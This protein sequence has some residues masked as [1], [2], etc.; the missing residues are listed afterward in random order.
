[1]LITKESYESSPQIEVLALLIPKLKGESLDFKDLKELVELLDLSNEEK[2]Y[3]FQ[4]A[5]SKLKKESLTFEDLEELIRL[6]ELSQDNDLKISIIE[7]GIRKLKED[8]LNSGRIETLVSLVESADQEVLSDDKEFSRAEYV[9]VT[10]VRRSKE[11]SL[12]LKDLEKLIKLSPKLNELD[13]SVI[14]YI[15]MAISKLKSES[16]TFEDLKALVALEEKEV[17]KK[18]IIQFAIPKLKEGSLT[19]NELKELR[20]L[21]DDYYNEE[22]VIEAGIPKLKEKSLT[23]SEL[24]ELLELFA[25]NYSKVKVIG[26]G[27]PKLKEGSLAINELKELWELFDDDYNKLKVITLVITT[28]KERLN[29]ET[30]REIA[31]HFTDPLNKAT[32]FGIY[33]K[34]NKEIDIQNEAAMDQIIDIVNKESLG[35]YYV[36]VMSRMCEEVGY[37]ASQICAFSNKLYPANETLKVEFINE[38]LDI[39]A[40]E[41]DLNR[42]KVEEVLKGFIDKIS[43]DKSKEIL[44]LIENIEKKG[45]FSK[46]DILSLCSGRVKNQYQAINQFLGEKSLA[47]SLNKEALDSL[48]NDMGLDAADEKWEKET[49][50]GALF[51]YYDLKDNLGLGLFVSSLEPNIL[52]E[53]RD[54][55]KFPEDQLYLTSKE[56][57]DLG[58]LLADKM[59]EMSSMQL[60]CDHLAAKIP[61]IPEISD[62]DHYKIVFPE[63]YLTNG[64]KIELSN[65]RKVF[66][67]SKFIALFREANTNSPILS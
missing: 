6:T 19:I 58:V 43:P 34:N 1:M 3:V 55:F 46:K 33:F 56:Y 59:P 61:P 45:L 62:L 39:P 20:G 64:E 38:C 32:I 67:N 26:A 17:I 54:N 12:T 10:G 48:K 66:L 31:N 8:M 53:L 7:N 24:K 16:F 15:E 44:L 50:L 5:I 2:G 23:I 52:K 9:F 29:I 28:L 47:K 60:L 51:S 57:K 30:I 22:K 35:R 41:D 42:D 18:T 37:S 11:E 49:T 65:A 36:E 13:V 25:S 4:F 14:Y 63:Y 27:I 40:F 21:F